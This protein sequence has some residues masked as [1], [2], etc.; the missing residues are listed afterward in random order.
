MEQAGMVC[1]PCLADPPAH[2]GI[3]AA[4]DYG[5]IARHLVLRLKYGRKPGLAAVMARRMLRHAALFP[6]AIMVPVPL[7]WTRLWQRGFNQSLLI[8]RSIARQTGLSVRSD[9]LHRARRTRALGGQGRAARAREVRGAFSL[10]KAAP[11]ILAGRDVLL[12]DDVYTT[13]ATANACARLLKR[14]GRVR[15]VR[16]LCWA[17]VLNDAL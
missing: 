13:G 6:D 11:N 8:A 1:A 14:T 3:F 17:R 2:D 4:V 16:V 10:S 9:L 7:H 15:S 12:V 5:P